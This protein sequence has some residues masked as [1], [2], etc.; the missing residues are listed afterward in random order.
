MNLKFWLLIEDTYNKVLKGDCERV[1][2]IRKTEAYRWVSKKPSCRRY[3][4]AVVC[5]I[6]EDGQIISLS[7]AYENLHNISSSEL[8]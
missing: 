1:I 7:E 6:D 2:V 5:A 8:R 4:K 3:I